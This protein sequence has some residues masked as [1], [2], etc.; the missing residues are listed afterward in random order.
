[1]FEF[2]QQDTT[3]QGRTRFGHWKFLNLDMVW[4]LLFGAWDF[5]WQPIQLPLDY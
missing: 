2:V 4:I 5:S 3:L 1:V